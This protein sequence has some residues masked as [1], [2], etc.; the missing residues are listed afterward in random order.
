MIT[1]ISINLHF[2]NSLK[3]ED[4]LKLSGDNIFVYYSWKQ[5]VRISPWFS[6]LFEMLSRRWCLGYT[7][8]YVLEK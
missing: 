1:Q 7:K 2:V 6:Y 4:S 5:Y 8:F 3:Y